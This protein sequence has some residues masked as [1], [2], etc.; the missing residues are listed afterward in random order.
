MPFGYLTGWFIFVCL[1]QI[2]LTLLCK[3]FAPLFFQRSRTTGFTSAHAMD[4]SNGLRNVSPRKTH[5]NFTFIFC[6]IV[7]TCECLN[8]IQSNNGNLSFVRTDS[9]K[10]TLGKRFAIEKCNNK[11][12][13]NYSWAI[14]CF[15]LTVNEF[16]SE[17]MLTIITKV[18]NF[19]TFSVELWTFF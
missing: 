15:A 2:V 13:V 14:V 1:F 5:H 6:H 17:S 4:V 12:R 11:K 19:N 3:S 8:K 9:M 7:K 16:W 18:L 10:P